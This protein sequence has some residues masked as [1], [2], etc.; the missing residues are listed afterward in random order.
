[1][2]R[3]T[4]S[5]FWVICGAIVVLTIF[6]FLNNRYNIIGTIF[7]YERT[8]VSEA[9]DGSVPE[10]PTFIE[11]VETDNKYIVYFNVSKNSTRYRCVYGERQTGL[12]NSAIVE[13]QGKKVS[14]NVPKKAESKYVQIL[15]TNYD[16]ETPSEIIALN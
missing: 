4:N 8:E 1:M 7:Q 5:L 9:D 3:N 6:A 10:A 12:Y 14:C 2:A 13:V 16:K 11:T 15:G